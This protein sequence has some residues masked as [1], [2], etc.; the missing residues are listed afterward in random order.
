M[1]KNIVGTWTICMGFL[2]GSPKQKNASWFSITQTYSD[3]TINQAIEEIR[4]LAY[5]S[6]NDICGDIVFWMKD[7]NGKFIHE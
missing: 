5:S 6:N 3:C 4:T 2:T 7:K 1:K